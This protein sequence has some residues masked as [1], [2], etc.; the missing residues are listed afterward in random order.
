MSALSFLAAILVVVIKLLYWQS[1]VPV[2]YAS[3]IVT[4]C[5]FASIQIFLLGILGEYVLATM[6]YVRKMPMVVE[7]ERVGTW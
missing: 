2:G 4:I 3:G 6:T 1:N 7:R 5:F